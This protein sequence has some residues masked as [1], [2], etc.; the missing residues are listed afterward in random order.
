MD[1]TTLHP[2][3]VVLSV[4]GLA[5]AGVVLWTFVRTAQRRAAL[6]LALALLGH[7]AFVGLVLLLDAL[8]E[9]EP[10]KPT[11]RV[12]EV[13]TAPKPKPKPPEPAPVPKAPEPEPEVAPPEPVPDAP[14]P[15]PKA[16]PKPRTKRPKRAPK[17]EPAPAP[18]APATPDAPPL[19]FNAKVTTQ[20]GSSGVSV[21]TGPTSEGRSGGTGKPGSGRRKAGGGQG[22]QGTAPA[23]GNG[24]AA[25]GWKPTS[26]VQVKKLPL[27]LDVPR[28]S[29]PATKSEGVVGTVALKVQVRGDGRVR[30]VRV[31]KG[32][33]HGCDE[34][35]KRALKKARFEPAVRTDGKPADYE[36]RYEY[37]FEV[38]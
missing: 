2:A 7:A 23:T 15:E 1:D 34:V 33:G 3:L 35:A 28:I 27:P 19:R 5:V 32:I 37:V 12:Y 38:N 25:D 9:D 21:R 6:S 10:K 8:R 16:K 20:G 22:G 14:P 11:L 29:C 31:V 26:A 30:R 18:T 36:L 17:A 4:G 24:A 13:A